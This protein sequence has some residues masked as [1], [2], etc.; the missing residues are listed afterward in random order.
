MGGLEKEKKGHKKS[1][2]QMSSVDFL[3]YATKH[4]K[5]VD[6]GGGFVNNKP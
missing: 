2:S 1:D 5:S 6:V 4:N 3:N